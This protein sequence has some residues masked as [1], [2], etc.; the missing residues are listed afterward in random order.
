M[1]G[2]AVNGGRASFDAARRETETVENSRLFKGLVRT[3]F[4]ARAI[5]YGV[6][7]ALAFAIALGAG[8]MGEPANQQGALALIA[9]SAVGRAALVVICCG[10]LAYGVWKLTQG[11]F[12]RGPEGGGARD[13]KGRVAS[14]G[15]ATVYLGFFAV[16]TRVLVGGSGNS[17]SEPR[18][19][20]AGVLDWPGGQLIVGIAGAVLIG[21]SLYQ[22]YDG[23][24]GGFATAD[25]TREMGPFERRLF[26]VVGYTGLVARA[27][28]FAVVGYFLLRT[29]IDFS[30]GN[31]VGVD[32]ALARLH[33]Q[34]LG[35]EA[36]GLVA[37]GLITFA[38]FSLLEARYR[39]L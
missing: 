37:F 4:L 24:R 13:V 10:L 31:A 33:H 16:A 26:M 28:V 8:T 19:A 18:R 5:T 25:K 15:G 22:L 11:V 20:A 32:G 12:G 17:A 38:L 34:P 2:L 6:I 36:L 23:V 7:G 9:R 27:I 14:L 21:I 1:K 35:P 30:P 3:G 39:R 29:A